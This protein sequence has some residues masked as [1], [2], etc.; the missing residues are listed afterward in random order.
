MGTLSRSRHTKIF[1]LGRM[2]RCTCTLCPTPHSPF[3]PFYGRKIKWG[4]RVER[5]LMKWVGIF[6]VG[7]FQRGVWWVE[8]FRAGI[9]PWGIFLEPF[10]LM[11]CVIKTVSVSLWNSDK[12]FS[13]I[14][15]SWYDLE[16]SIKIRSVQVSLER[17]KMCDILFYSED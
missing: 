15:L 14:W 5:Q 1:H 13:I 6:Q 9:I 7:I 10:N 3:P 16:K 17:F 12:P 11:K 4:K 8:I 2:G